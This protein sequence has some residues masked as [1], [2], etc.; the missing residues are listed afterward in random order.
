MID[1]E[2]LGSFDPDGR[3]PI[4]ERPYTVVLGLQAGDSV[5]EHTHPGRDILFAVVDGSLTLTVGEQSQTL[6][7]GDLARFDGDNGISVTADED[8]R[9]LVVLS[10]Q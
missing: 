6:D 9:A 2:S 4:F 3:T 10:D 1:V 7:A 5:P 8:V